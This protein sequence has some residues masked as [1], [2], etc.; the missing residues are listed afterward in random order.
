VVE[1]EP[2]RARSVVLD[3]VRRALA[4]VPRGE[5]PDDHAVARDYDL[6]SPGIDTS[7]LFVE[8]VEDYRAT[9]VRI[10][11]DQVAVRA[12]E[13]LNEHGIARLVLPPGLPES[14]VPVGAELVDGSAASNE[15]LERADGVMTG[16]AVAIA[17]TGTIVLD[18][19]PG[20]GRR[21]LTLVVDFHL[22]VVGVDQIY[23]G[24]PAAIRAL[25]DR[26]R[27]RRPPLTFVSGPSA[28]SDIEF[29]RVEGVHGPRTLVVLLVE[30][31]IADAPTVVPG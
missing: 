5:N 11:T 31:R 29:R 25:G 19:G 7:S 17:P 8:R 26:V 9:V 28:T 14:W 6:H 21:A 16:C 2:L 18:G 15:D 10:A 1:R 13:F 4:D 22:C 27:T 20:Q 30:G 3:A 12:A 23:D 24:V